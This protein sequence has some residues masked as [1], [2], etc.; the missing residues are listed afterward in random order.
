M[1]VSEMTLEGHVGVCNNV[2][3]LGVLCSSRLGVGEIV[4]ALCICPSCW[5]T[6]LAKCEG[7]LYCSE[8]P[9]N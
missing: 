7:T 2:H 8:E 9:Q 5:T 3:G 1:G 4:T 6:L